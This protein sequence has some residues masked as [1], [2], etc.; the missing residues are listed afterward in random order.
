MCSV[1]GSKPA[2]EVY[3]LFTGVTVEPVEAV[4]DTKGSL[5]SNCG[6]IWHA[7]VPKLREEFWQLKRQAAE[8]ASCMLGGGVLRAM[9][10]RVLGS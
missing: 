6:V 10:G 2:V 9:Q 7:S 8:A 1:G 5:K 3:V 4:E